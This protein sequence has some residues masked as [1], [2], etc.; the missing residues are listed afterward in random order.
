[1]V[2]LT[3]NQVVKCLERLMGDIIEFKL[4]LTHIHTHT[5]IE[6]SH[7]YI[8]YTYVRYYIHAYKPTESI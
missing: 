3:E 2:L 5:E 7:T 6:I 4:L 8:L 1:M